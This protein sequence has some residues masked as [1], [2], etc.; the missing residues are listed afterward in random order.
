MLVLVTCPFNAFD[1]FVS[2]CKVTKEK[3]SKM[4]GSST[5]R[6]VADKPKVNECMNRTMHLKYFV[7]LETIYMIVVLCVPG[8][9][10]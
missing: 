7:S 4:D 8:V 3:H 6:K 1:V 5:S 9:Y 2:L 10:H